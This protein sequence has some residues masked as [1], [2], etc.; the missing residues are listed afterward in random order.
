VTED[1]GQPF[2]KKELAV[3]ERSWCSEGHAVRRAGVP[4]SENVGISNELAMRETWPPN[5]Q[6]FLGNGNRPR[7]S[8]A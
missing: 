2:R 4:R 8:R 5:T 1:T 6:G 7:V 3:E